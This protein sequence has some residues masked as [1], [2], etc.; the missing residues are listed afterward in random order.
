MD[1]GAALTLVRHY[2]FDRPGYKE[3][4]KQKLVISG[5]TDFRK[6]AFS[7]PDLTALRNIHNPDQAAYISTTPNLSTAAA[8]SAPNLLEHHAKSEPQNPSVVF[9]SKRPPR[10]LQ[11]KRTST[12]LRQDSFESSPSASVAKMQR[13]VANTSLTSMDREHSSPTE[14]RAQT[15]RVRRGLGRQS[16]TFEIQT[17][18]SAR[19]RG[20]TP[21]QPDVQDADEARRVEGTTRMDSVIPDPVNFAVSSILSRTQSEFELWRK[22][23]HI[24][25]AGDCSSG[26]DSLPSVRRS[27]STSGVLSFD[28]T[29]RGS[30]MS[31]EGVIETF[32][33][34]S[35]Q[36]SK[37]LVK[38]NANNCSVIDHGRAV[39]AAKNLLP[40]DEPERLSHVRNNMT[41][42][43][44]TLYKNAKATTPPSNI[45]SR[46][47]AIE[48]LLEKILDHVV[49]RDL[50]S[51][52]RVNKSLRQN[53]T[54]TLLYRRRLFI[55][56][57]PQTTK[58]TCHLNPLLT[59]LGKISRLHPIHNSIQISSYLPPPELHGEPTGPILSRP[60]H[61]HAYLLQRF[62]NHASN[63]S[64]T[65][66]N[67]SP[68]LDL[69]VRELSTLETSTHTLIIPH[70][71]SS[72]WDMYLCQPP[73]S[74]VRIT[75]W[76]REGGVAS[77]REKVVVRGWSLREIFENLE[78]ARRGAGNV[79][80][81]SGSGR[82][83]GKKDRGG[84]GEMM[85][86]LAKAMLAP[87]W[88][89]WGGM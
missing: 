66:N 86:R 19:A 79:E 50:I 43:D 2:D 73:P 70:Q 35:D 6:N 62:Y 21:E 53:L 64:L 29:L 46:V 51:L 89:E 16:S 68:T 4:K 63:P 32:Q 25:T 36:V 33:S 3:Q 13:T 85:V 24:T 71:D 39:Q 17:R 30:A 47:F 9:R 61:S 42:Y 77:V 88:A 82:V 38:R 75:V 87:K 18:D 26:D 83:G 8:T 60:G 54:T 59:T 80:R 22:S 67:P 15:I 20:L 37:R 81:G 72:I 45:A 55:S 84:K 52:Q 74:E 58:Q 12:N 57:S 56:P 40:E 5:P 11:K 69:E 31:D 27:R 65:Y 23:A 10:R 76:K 34:A 14:A 78:E 48:E 41:D 28:A 49:F 1:P 7:N 44:S